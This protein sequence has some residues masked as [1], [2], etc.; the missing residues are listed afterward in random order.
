MTPLYVHWG[1][2]RRIAFATK[3][4]RWYT[5][6]V[7]S[8][9]LP[10]ASGLVGMSAISARRSLA[11]LVFSS[12]VALPLLGA[13]GSPQFETPP[14]L[15]AAAI[16]P[17]AYL[18]G[19]YHK[20]NNKVTSDGY[21]NNYTI[22]SKFG[23][24]TVEGQQLLEIRIGELIALAELEKMSSSKVLGD[25]A[26]EGGKAVVTAPVKAVGKVVDTVSDP[27]KVQDTV[28]GIPDGAERLFSWAYKQAKSGVQVVGDQFSSSSTPAP[29]D[30]YSSGSTLQAGKKLGLD[31]LGYSKKE[32]EL[33]RKLECN[34][35]TSNK[36]VQ[37]EVS[38]VVS[39]ETTVGV[40]FKFVPSVALLSQ[41]NTFNTW[42]D[43]ANKLSLYE[44]PE[45]IFKKNKADLIS[46]GVTEEH[47][48]AFLKNESYNPWTQRFVANSLHE[49]GPKVDGHDKFIVL[50][51]KADNEPTT[52]YFVSV[53]D[54]LQKLHSKRPLKK[55]VSGLHLPAA[56]TKDGMLYLPLSVDYLFW[57]EE[58]A[59]ILSDFKAR[60]MTEE[61]FTT[62]EVRI[63]G[64]VS[65]MARQKIEA[66]GV[67]VT[68]GP[69]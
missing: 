13:G 49:I 53:A 52:L 11:L 60:V 10:A 35:Y 39:I 40:A 66:M 26:Y 37:S 6:R 4:R 31:Y 28:A 5:F 16:L 59:G 58:V 1:A 56:V 41:L 27:K 19:P 21:F 47:A 67:K 12:L 46:L 25:S 23:N 22:E 33:F 51:S 15:S 55:I 38:R 57:T 65:P 3:I 68:E 34:P 9:P 64:R 8:R 43:R 32:R 44:E 61:K 48:L 29:D 36:Q 69:L 17:K 45:G 63:R 20:L 7:F 24:E 2:Q 30:G 42:Y 54:A 62:A 50:A 18:S 14:V